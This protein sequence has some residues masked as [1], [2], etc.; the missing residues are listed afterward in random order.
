MNYWWATQTTNYPAAIVSGTLWTCPRAEDRPLKESRR[1]IKDLRVGDVVF[2][3]QASYLRAVSIVAE[4]WQDHSRPAEYVKRVGEGEEGWLVRVRPIATGLKL[5]FRRV[6]ELIRLSN[7]GPLNIN[8]EPSQKYLSPLSREEGQK[9]LAELDVSP[10]DEGFMGRP[11]D[12][13]GGEETDTVKLATLRAEQSELRR[14]LLDGRFTAECSI[15]G[16]AFPA[17]LLIAGH[18]KPRSIC[19]EEER[20]DFGSVAMLIC[21]LGCDALFE[22]GYL[23]VDASGTVRA[24][25]SPETAGVKEAVLEVAGNDCLAFNVRTASTFAA[26]SHLHRGL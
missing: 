18:I 24:G 23:I 16:R 10:P 1:L 21:N 14:H 2:H 5:H 7:G 19:T 8:S 22:W 26:H 25:K 11:I 17:R 13:W 20:K 4:E 6:G 3:H 9:L 15:C 12:S